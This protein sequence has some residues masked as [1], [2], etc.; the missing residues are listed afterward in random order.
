MIGLGRHDRPPIPIAEIATEH[1]EIRRRE[2]AR[3]R[4]SAAT[5]GRESARFRRAVRDAYRST[6]IVCGRS[7]PPFWDDGK[8]GM[9]AIHLLPESEFG[10]NQVSNGICLCKLHRWA[11]DEGIVEIVHD[12]AIGYAIT[13]PQ[14]AEARAGSQG[15]DLSIVRDHAGPIP[16]A[17]L[18]DSPQAR[19]NPECLRRLSELLHP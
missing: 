2:L 3:Q 9:D 17:R 12:A 1:P 11:V 13:I 19:P 18:P 5:Q 6:C 7:F 8:A 15:F 4:R 14:E 16:L 10:L